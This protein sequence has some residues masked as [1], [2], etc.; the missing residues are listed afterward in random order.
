MGPCPTHTFVLLEVVYLRS[1]YLIFILTG[2]NEPQGHHDRRYPQL[3]PAVSAVHP[4]QLR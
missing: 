2:V 3:P 4:V 1:K